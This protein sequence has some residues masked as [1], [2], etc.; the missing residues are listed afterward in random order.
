[1]EIYFKQSLFHFSH[2]SYT[3][4]IKLPALASFLFICLTCSTHLSR[5][6]L[7]ISPLGNSFLISPL[8][9]TVP[10]T[11]F[12]ATLLF[13]LN[14]G[15]NLSAC[16]SSR[17]QAYSGQQFLLLTTFSLVFKSKPGPWRVLKIYRCMNSENHEVGCYYLH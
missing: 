7:D 11:Y 13:G 3:S 16:F 1:M 17:L 9:L 12:K 14:C 6:S 10:S 8:W 5:F 15:Y 4:Y 2:V